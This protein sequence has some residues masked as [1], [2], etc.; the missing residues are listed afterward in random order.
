MGDVDLLAP[1]GS[2]CSP[3]R[4]RR[5]LTAKRCGR[6]RERRG[7]YP[8]PPSW[9]QRYD[10]KEIEP[11]WQRVWADERTWQVDNAPTSPDVLRA[12][13]APVHLPAARRTS[14]T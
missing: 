10:P 1:R 8:S 3:A 13:D 2:P 12:R 11:R 6:G 14:A 7:L 5:G 9:L 4:A